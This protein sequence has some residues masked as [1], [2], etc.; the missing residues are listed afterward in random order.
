MK[1][2]KLFINY[3]VLT[4]TNINEY[5]KIV[6][7]IIRLKDISSGKEKPEENNYPVTGKLLI[8]S[9]DPKI[10]HINWI[11]YLRGICE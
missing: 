8:Y 3:Y 10:S 9:T 1:F 5:F 11:Y 6:P 4:N 7:I 2:K